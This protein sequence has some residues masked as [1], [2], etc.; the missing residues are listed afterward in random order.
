MGRAIPGL[1]LLAILFTILVILNRGAERDASPPRYAAPGQKALPAPEVPP[2]SGAP[3]LPA[4]AGD[5]SI[6]GFVRRRHA[7]LAARIE[8]R[9]SGADELAPPGETV[10]TLVAAA[11][12]GFRVQGLPPGGYHVTAVAE[13][14][15]R[16]SAAVAVRPD[17]RPAP[18]Y[19]LVPDGSIVVEGRAV[20]TDGHSFSGR[21]GVV[22]V[23]HLGREVGRL[24]LVRT[25]A[26]GRFTLRG[27]EPGEYRPVAYDP[28]RFRVLLAPLRLPVPGEL[29]LVVDAGLTPVTATV[30]ADATGKPVAGALVQ[31]SFHDESQEG[32]GPLRLVHRCRTDPE[33]RFPT[34]LRVEGHVSAAGFS[35]AF[36]LFRKIEERGIVRL[37]PSGGAPARG[38][39]RGRVVEAGTG[40]PARGAVVVW[41]GTRQSAPAGE[42]GE[43]AIEAAPA[44]PSPGALLCVR[45]GGWFSPELVSLRALPLDPLR[46]PL[47]PGETVER[48]LAAV[49]AAAVRGRVVDASGRPVAGAWVRLD[50]S[51]AAPRGRGYR[52]SYLWND[53]WSRRTRT[54]GDGTFR[55]GDL[56][57]EAEHRVLVEPETG[58]TF[59]AGPFSAAAGETAEV[60]VKLPAGGSREVRVVF[61]DTGEPVAGALIAGS[62]FAG[63]AGH[64]ALGPYLTDRDG[65]VE[66]GPL[67]AG[68]AALRIFHEEIV[69]ERESYPFEPAPGPFV[70]EVERGHLLGGR[71]AWPDGSPAAGAWVLLEGERL[72]KR[73]SEEEARTD[74]SG[75]FRIVGLPEG[76]SGLVY[77]SA[78]RDGEGYHAEAEAVL[79]RED[80]VLV[81]GPVEAAPPAPE[82]VVR[83][84]TPDG[85]PVDLCQVVGW[86]YMGDAYGRTD[87]ID[88]WFRDGAGRI[89]FPR[90]SG[91]RWV[92]VLT[93]RQGGKALGPAFVGPLEIEVGEI[94]VRLPPARAIEGRVLDAGGGPV[95]GAV[96]TAMPVYPDVPNA[97]RARAPH[98]KASSARDGTF[99]VEGLG[100]FAYD[101]FVEVPKGFARPRPCRARAGE[102]RVEIHLP[103]SVFVN[104]TVLGWQGKPVERAG[105]SV[106]Y[107][108]SDRP[109]FEP[110]R[111][112]DADGRHRLGP[113]DPRESYRLG[114]HVHDPEH[115]G[116]E[117]AP[118]TPED[119]VLR[120]ARAYSIIGRVLSSAGAPAPGA[121]VRWRRV[122]DERGSWSRSG[123]DGTFEIHRL[124]AGMVTLRASPRG[125]SID[126]PRNPEVT[127]AAGSEDVILTV[128]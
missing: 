68:K 50:G 13:D 102:S 98:G 53:S 91:R 59:L 92:E 49:R 9:A 21:V 96:V 51:R 57:P 38:T 95:V 33:G 74:P 89:R 48:D 8:V 62:L 63:D 109:L 64:L 7:P 29:R 66:I 101:L 26:N 128:D 93:A 100:N 28:G 77:A 55:F 45:G 22:R 99:R 60:L 37:R 34:Y 23:D 97:E 82:L 12:G 47:K 113:L 87:R 4:A 54:D 44:H 116:L 56:L 5:G 127:V 90:I 76:T 25:D 71:V 43:Y 39:I 114:V 79:D 104:L 65:V 111:W 94:E 46:V 58:G 30:V 2:E 78:E 120:L 88:G 67:S 18:L 17:T 124:P 121:V 70:I 32:I 123:E 84:T 15:A 119:S 14:G 118:W 117:L 85:R 16:I 81:L 86:N 105:I 20:H 125:R 42:G 52:N 103:G 72:G 19:L 27:L 41:R 80:H 31:G 3:P 110:N 75:R 11:D 107:L 108:D 126:D 24:P 69:R 1:A 35:D 40:A 122:R 6:H 112:T 36:F 73:T 10:R 115:L 106:R 83:V 61:A